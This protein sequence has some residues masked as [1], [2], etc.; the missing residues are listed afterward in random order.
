[1]TNLL[2]RVKLSREHEGAACESARK[3]RK[4][5]ETVEL[6]IALKNYDPQ[7]DKRF[8]GTVKLKH[9]PRPKF[10][11]CVLGDQQPCDEAKANNLACMDTE[12]LKKL[13]K[14]KKLVKKLAKKYDA[15]MASESLIK[16]IPRLLGP[17]LNKAGKFPTLL[18]HNESMMAKLN[19]VKATIKFQMKKESRL[20]YRG[21]RRVVLRLLPGVGGG[22]RQGECETAGGVANIARLKRLLK[23]PITDDTTS[24]SVTVALESV[25]GTSFWMMGPKRTCFA[26]SSVASE[27]LKIPDDCVVPVLLLHEYSRD[28]SSEMS[29]PF[30]ALRP[31]ASFVV[32]EASSVSAASIRDRGELAAHCSATL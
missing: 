19:E 29:G 4:F 13:N 1:M 22:T 16:Q 15:F 2:R 28:K 7:K 30:R 26:C 27:D 31:R 20:P 10:Q 32:S 5:L 6:Q 25:A 24:R 21:K 3:H 17:G 11:V 12:A 9:I 18:N 8:S 14:S 23:A